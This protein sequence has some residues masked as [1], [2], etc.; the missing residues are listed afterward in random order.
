MLIQ[1]VWYG[2]IQKRKER[3]LSSSMR[4]S[5]DHQDTVHAHLS[6]LP[7]FHMA[8]LARI[9]M[10]VSL[11]VIAMPP[12]TAAA[13]SRLACGLDAHAELARQLLLLRC[14][15]PLHKHDGETLDAAGH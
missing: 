11:N 13:A 7:A 12:C 14:W 1:Y 9:Y 2:T 8:V 10:P 5:T 15:M 4:R 6:R 3:R